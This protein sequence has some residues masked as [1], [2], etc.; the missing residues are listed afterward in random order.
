MLP[1]MNTMDELLATQLDK[2]GINDT[3]TNSVLVQHAL[4][5]VT[6]G[7]ATTLSHAVAAGM[8]HDPTNGAWNMDR[9]NVL[10]TPISLKNLIVRQFIRDNN[11]TIKCDAFGFSVKDFMTHRVILRCDS[12]GDLYPVTAPPPIPHVFLLS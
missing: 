4:S 5:T 10:I 12:T 8:V 3:S 1:Q 6:S 2:L 7:Q 9:D 11:C